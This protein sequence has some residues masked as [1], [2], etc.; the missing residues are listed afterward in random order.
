MPGSLLLKRTSHAPGGFVQFETSNFSNPYQA[1]SSIKPTL[2]FL[3]LRFFVGRRRWGR[4]RWWW[5]RGV[6]GNLYIKEGVCQ[7]WNA[8]CEFRDRSVPAGEVLGILFFLGGQAFWTPVRHCP[9]YPVLHLQWSVEVP[10]TLT[11][12]RGRRNYRK[13][14]KIYTHTIFRWIV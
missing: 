13:V 6:P 10:I 1:P 11:G 14:A 2:F 7:V 4:R 8:L 5:E 12:F 9:C 3:Y